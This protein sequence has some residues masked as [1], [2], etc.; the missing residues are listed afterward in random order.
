MTVRFVAKPK[1]G[2]ESL[3]FHV[4]TNCVTLSALPSMNLGFR[5]KTL[6]HFWSWED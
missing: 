6:F 1:Y 4:F 5:D 2:F 3:Y